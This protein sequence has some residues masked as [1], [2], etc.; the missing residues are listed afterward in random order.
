M[1]R[2]GHFIGHVQVVQLARKIVFRQP[3]PSGLSLTI[4]FHH[5]F[6][7]PADQA[8]RVTHKVLQGTRSFG[9]W[10]FADALE[11]DP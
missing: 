5:V 9:T 3:V 11:A 2:A 7:N 6:A 4:H 10:A 1:M 8:A